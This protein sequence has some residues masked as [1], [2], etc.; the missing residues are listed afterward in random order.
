MTTPSPD[1]EAR[2]S[3]EKRI[4]DLAHKLAEYRQAYYNGLPLVS[5][6]AFDAL[7]DELRELAPDHPHFGAVG[8]EPPVVSEWEKARHMLPMGSLNKVTSEEEL[9]EWAARCDALAAQAGVPPISADLTV[10]EKLDGL[11]LELVYVKGAFT[12]G[13]TRG[14]GEIG[15]RITPNVRRMKG[16]PARLKE[17]LSL[18]VRGEIVMRL[19]DWRAHFAEAISPRNAASGTSKRFD[20]KGSEHLSV[21]CYDVEGPELGSE[22]DKL[23]LLERLGFT[24]PGW[25]AH[26]DLAGT[27]ALHAAYANERRAA[28][29]YDIDGLVVRA[30]SV[31]AQVVL[32]DLNRRPRAAVAFKFASEA[33]VT[34]VVD[35]AWETGPSG[36]VVPVAFVEPVEL[37]KATVRRASLHNASLVRRLGIGKG[38]EVLVSRRND[39]IPYVEEV[40]THGGQPTVVPETCGVCH[41]PL[42][43]DGEYL[44]CRNPDCPARVEGRIKAWVGAL[45]LL[46]WGDKLVAQICHERSVRQPGDLYR[47]TVEDIATLERRG[48]KSGR[49]VLEQ[50]RGR[51]EVPLSTFLAGLGI[52]NFSIQ[53]ARLVVRA[54]FD[55]VEKVQKASAE[56]L[57]AIF[58]L[59]EIK[60][61]QIRAGLDDKAEVIRGLLDAG[62]R[63][64]GETVDGPLG[65]KSFCFTGEMQRSRGELQEL[66]ERYGGLVKT[67]VTKDLD[68]LVLSDPT[69]TST[70]AEKARR[71]GTRCIGEEEFIA[72]LPGATA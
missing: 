37:A 69:S 71:F 36:R 22:E 66:V 5:D 51:M 30:R 49:K 31:H 61:R 68:Y 56:E 62:V 9:R 27:L 19:S 7:E 6:A 40:V 24:L 2:R 20:G 34:R 13:I 26:T 53:T 52:D 12:D 48:E 70:K 47:L 50:L 63:T 43:K 32:G 57:A 3:N 42:S 25:E 14:D 72:M 17:P 46:E 58:G 4:S 44:N 65:G 8:A 1:P 23:R 55:S 67:S 54:G 21:L 10:T 15:E 11:S 60:A 28:L 39:V 64:T 35:V 59:G 38:D 29:D 18:S 16:V 41:A 33:K 45:G